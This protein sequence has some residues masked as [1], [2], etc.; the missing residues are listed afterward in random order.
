[1]KHSLHRQAIRAKQTETCELR[2]LSR[3][4]SGNAFTSCN[5]ICVCNM[6]YIIKINRIDYVWKSISEQY[7][8]IKIPYVEKWKDYL[9]MS[10]I[11]IRKM[12]NNNVVWYCVVNYT[13]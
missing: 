8:L 13:G 7:R 6:S 2:S 3:S 12:Y 10:N 11:L 1:M 5:S 4:Y 9:S